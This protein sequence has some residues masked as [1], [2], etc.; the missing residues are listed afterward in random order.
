MTG[1][2]AEANSIA[3]FSIPAQG[4]TTKNRSWER[5]LSSGTAYVIDLLH[6]QNY[7]VGYACFPFAFD[8][9]AQKQHRP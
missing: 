7:P 3:I 8:F 9:S 1:G 6:V 4:S 2:P 5:S